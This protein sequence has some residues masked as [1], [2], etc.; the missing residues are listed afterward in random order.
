MIAPARPL[1]QTRNAI[2]RDPETATLYLEE[3]LAAGDTEAF[4]LA[5]P[6]VV[7]A[8]GGMTALAN[9]T[10]LSR[11]ALYRTLSGSGNPTLETL[12]RVLGALGLRVAVRVEGAAPDARPQA[13]Q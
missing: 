2:L 9:E 4:K 5:L 1:L 13:Q 11:E 3:A 7:E 10:A 12:S 6:N 8:R